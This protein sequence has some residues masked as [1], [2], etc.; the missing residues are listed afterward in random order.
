MPTETNL[1]VL[2]DAGANTDPTPHHML[3]NA[4]MGTVYSRHVLGYA[5]PS[6]G[7]MSIGTED[8]KG[9]DFTRETFDLLKASGLTFRGNVEGHDLFENPVEVVVADGFTGNC[10]FEDE[11]GHRSRHLRLAQARVVSQSAHQ[12]RRVALGASLQGDS[13]EDELRG[14]RRDAFA[15]RQR[16]LHH[17]PRREFAARRAQRHS[18]GRAKP[19]GTKSIHTSSKKCSVMN[20]PQPRTRNHQSNRTVSIIGTGSYV[21]ER[22]LT[23]ADLE[24]LVETSDEW[25]TT[26]TGIKERRIAAAGRMHERSRH[27]GRARRDGKCRHHR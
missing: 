26:R 22:V 25:I 1:F 11:R 27:Q 4:I 19:S 10:R 16:S 6:V 23:N 21:P 3:Q 5:N 17:R 9:N 7:L 15:R 12:I 2:I 18:H 20:P 8:E 14:L 24:R 13:Q